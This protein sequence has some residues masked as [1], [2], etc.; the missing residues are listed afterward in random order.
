MTITVRPSILR[1]SQ[2]PE[3]FGLVAT[4]KMGERVTVQF[5]QCGL[6][7]RQFRDFLETTTE[8]GGKWSLFMLPHVPAT[9]QSSGLLRA[10]WRDGVSREVE[11][12]MRAF[13]E[14]QRRPG[15]R[16]RVR[17]GGTQSFWRKRVLV[18]RFSRRLGE[19]VTMRSLLLTESS[20]SRDYGLP[21]VDSLTEDFRP[22]VP[23]G[24]TIRAVLPLAAARPC[25]LAG[26]SRLQ[27]T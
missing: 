8:D 1:Y 2:K 14:L 22:T 25:Y 3:I 21:G 24:T 6:Y 7:P 5:R 13:V 19:W 15:G 9:L 26:Y 16:F 12:R 20:G 11:I 17:V 10:V 27:R 23:K 4:G 18:Q